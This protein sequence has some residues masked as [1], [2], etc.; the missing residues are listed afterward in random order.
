MGIGSAIAPRINEA[1]N[2]LSKFNET[3]LNQ[4]RGSLPAEIQPL[5][6]PGGVAGETDPLLGPRAR[7]CVAA[8]TEAIA[9]CDGAVN[10]TGT[11][12]R[13]ARRLGLAAGVAAMVGSSSVLATVAAQSMLLT[14]VC[15]LIALA[16]SVLTFVADFTTRPD[17]GGKRTV[18]DIYM[19][20]SQNRHRAEQ[21]RGEL[22]AH[23]EVG[24]TPKSE[25]E[26]S[27]LIGESNALCLSMIELST[28]VSI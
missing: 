25:P 27:R 8:L 6:K 16:G 24:V 14:I 5:L 12:L 13:W 3:S 7:V 26:V 9:R 21:L 10:V 11:R 18:F 1:V 20:L 15:G 2:F 4:L 23:L 28:A 19:Q 22:S 17:Q